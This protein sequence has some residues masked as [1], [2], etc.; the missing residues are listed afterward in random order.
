MQNFE[1][2]PCPL[3]KSFDFTV[4]YPGTFPEDLSQE[5]L[6]KVYKSSSDQTI[7]EQVVKCSDCGL[8][9]LNPRLRSDLIVDSY[10]EGEDMAFVEQDPMRIK[11]FKSALRQVSKEYGLPLSNTTKVLDIGCAGGAFLRAAREL[12][13]SAV[14]VEPSK[15][16]GEYG[17]SQHGLDVR[18][19]TLSEQAFPEAN[20][21][22]VTLW[23]VIE[24]V[25]SPTDELREVSRILKP[26]GLLVVNYPDFGSL[27]SRLLGKKWPFLLSVHLVYYTRST[28]RR[29]LEQAG[30]EVADIRRHWQMLELGYVLKRAAV[31][32]SFIRFIGRFVES[33]GL[34]SVPFMYWVGQTRVVA[35]KKA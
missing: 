4:V 1:T 10:A 11:T 3:C 19:G 25:P 23:D 6:T 22:L 21:D 32:F 28:I 33:I 13:L 15:W 9:Y 5:F 34:G 8:V 18:S 7:F 17:R 35:R 30:F 27:A 24:H 16:L 26:A 14:G 31:Y 12:E 2:V 29:Q 20:F